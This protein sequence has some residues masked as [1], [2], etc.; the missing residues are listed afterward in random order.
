[1]R[2]PNEQEDAATN[3]VEVEMPDGFAFVSYEPVDGW[4][5]DVKTEKLDEP[6]EAEGEEITEQVDTV[7]FTADDPA[8]AIQPGQFRDFGLS[9]GMPGRRRPARRSSS[10]RSRP[11][12]TV[13]SC[14]GS[15]RRTPR[16]R[17]RS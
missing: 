2:V 15:A 4:S 5:V 9:V 13:T 16:S 7:T 3:K 6:I 17:R 10:P 8:A 14:A 1:M 11:T 12:T